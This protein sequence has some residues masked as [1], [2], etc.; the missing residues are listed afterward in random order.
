MPEHYLKTT[1]SNHAS[2]M[3]KGLPFQP[4]DE[5]EVIIRSCRKTKNKKNP[6]PLQGKPFLYIDPFEP[7]GKN[8]WDVLK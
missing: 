4:G 1:V 7:I 3:I 8:D 5:V 2:L 6:Y